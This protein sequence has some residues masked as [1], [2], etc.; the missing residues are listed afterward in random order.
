M[1]VHFNE[2]SLA[3]LIISSGYILEKTYDHWNKGLSFNIRTTEEDLVNFQ[4]RLTEINIYSV[5]GLS[6]IRYDRSVSIIIIP[7]SEFS[8]LQNILLNMLVDG[9]QYLIRKDNLFTQLNC[10]INPYRLI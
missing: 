7:F 4:Y 8:K 2:I 5:I 3:A 10:L 9:K 6:S 1:F